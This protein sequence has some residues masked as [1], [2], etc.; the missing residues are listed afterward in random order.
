MKNDI[1]TLTQIF[2]DAHIV[3]IDFSNWDQ[4]IVFC[5]LADHYKDWTVDRISRCPLLLVRFKLVREFKISFNN[6]D[7]GELVNGGHYQWLTE[8]IELEKIND[9]FFLSIAGAYSAAPN[10]QLI[11][12]DIDIEEVDHKYFDRKFPGW[13]KPGQG[14]V[15]P[16][17]HG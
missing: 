13:G 3:D 8:S 14:F 11:C 17:I 4:E 6:F 10:L 12:N 16:G 2:S 5:V 9:S 7:K 1:K 15:R